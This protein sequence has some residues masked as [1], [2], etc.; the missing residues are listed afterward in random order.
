M[1]YKI[2]VSIGNGSIEG[3]KAFDSSSNESMIVAF[4]HFSFKLDI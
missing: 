4:T 2:W 3:R 1:V